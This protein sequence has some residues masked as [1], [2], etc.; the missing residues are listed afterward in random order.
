MPKK[1]AEGKRAA[2]TSEDPAEKRHRTEEIEAGGAV[3]SGRA[4]FTESD[5][6]SHCNASG[7]AQRGE[8]IWHNRGSRARA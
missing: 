6:A 4:F 5:E 2:G 3:A 1:A 7:P 8:Y